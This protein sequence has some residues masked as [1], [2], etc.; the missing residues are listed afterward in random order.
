MWHVDEGD[1]HAY[2]DGALDQ[3][4][5]GPEAERIRAHLREC[6]DC[7]ARLAAETAVRAEADAIL[8]G[9]PVGAVDVP[10]FEDLRARA[11]EE[12]PGGGAGTGR[13]PGY[14]RLAWA[15]SFV[16]ALGAGWWAR[17]MTLDGPVASRM[18][19]GAEAVEA[20]RP[21][22]AAPR[23]DAA[24]GA[25]A[26]LAAEAAGGLVPPP[27][28]DRD[29]EGSQVVS[30]DVART[31]ERARRVTGT[32]GEE[33]AAEP[34]SVPTVRTSVLDTAAPAPPDPQAE[35]ERR[36]AR[37]QAAAKAVEEAAADAGRQMAQAP[38]PAAMSDE[39]GRE[40]GGTLAHP[41]LPV[42][43]VRWI[44][45]ARPELGV[46]VLQS[47]PGGEPLEVFRIAPPGEPTLLPPLPE[48]SAQW[49][50]ESEGGWVVLRGPVSADS[51]AVLARGLQEV[52]GG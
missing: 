32:A 48:G 9:T 16:V 30:E 3:V 42:S 2:L 44:D 5:P 17:Q 15:A 45:E 14:R 20:A 31:L 34:S 40:P 33:R 51:L 19:P 37:E 21:G 46:R 49:I 22:P 41:A 6:T 43:E 4:H 1:L 24:G 28:S 25:E 50:R 7:A 23:A 36:E 26:D 52:D 13:G 35:A 38:A 27:V 8:A 39:V 11:L 10:P 18:S 29:V 12:S 47:L